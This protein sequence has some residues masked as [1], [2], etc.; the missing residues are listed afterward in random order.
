M[1]FNNIVKFFTYKWQA[2]IG[3]LIIAIL[4]YFYVQYTKTITKSFYIKVDTPVLPNN[5]IFSEELPTFV[6]VHFYGPQEIMDLNQDNFRVLMINTGPSP[7][8]NKF[9]L[10]LLPPPPYPIQFQLEPSELE[11]LI[12][13]K[14]RKAL[15]IVPKYDIASKQDVHYINVNP[16]SIIIE[17]PEKLINRL[18]RL[19]LSSV[20]LSEKSNLYYGKVL[21]Q[22][23]PKF[24]KIVENQPF[25]I[26]LEIKY[27]S[28]EEYQQKTT[29]LPA[30]YLTFNEE[31]PVSCSNPTG[32]IELANDVKVL[33]TY[34]SRRYLTK[35]LL[36]AEVFCPVEVNSITQS[37]EPNTFISNLPVIIKN[38]SEI[39]DFEILKVKPLF[40]DIEFRLKKQPIINQLQKGL[41]E[42]LIR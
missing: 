17:G 24:T 32:R 6:K 20:I 28:E 40:V 7:G 36:K 12:D 26:Q 5:L 19:T 22:D 18:D 34:I 14:K 29:N 30:G 8:K 11:I 42:H 2:K 13:N 37:I 39:K 35:N 1:I 3:S 15:P 16:S 31:I 38:E 4:L 41:Q 10:E 33:I 25:E 9:K 23:I 21:I 27:F